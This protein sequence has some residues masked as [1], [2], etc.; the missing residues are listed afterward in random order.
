MFELTNDQL[1]WK[2]YIPVMGQLISKQS[3][4]HEH[5]VKEYLEEMVSRN[6]VFMLIITLFLNLCR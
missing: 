4:M 3:T 2:K 6:I 5:L 1:E